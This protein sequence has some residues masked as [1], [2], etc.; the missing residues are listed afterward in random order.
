MDFNNFYISGNGNECLVQVSYLLVYF[1][2]D[3]NMTS[4]SRSRH[5]WA[6]TS[7]AAC[8]A[9]VGAEQ[10]LI[11]DAVDQWPTRLHACVRANSGHCEYTLWLLICFLCTWWT[12]FH[13]TLDAVGNI[14]RVHYKNS[15]GD[16][17]ANVNFF[18]NIAQVEASAYA[19]WTSS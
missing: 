12:L 3:V 1:T 8:V 13:T 10:S 6:A 16:E 17:I 14:L 18:Y 2:C 7:S 11:G 15:S 9:R 4:L 5:W 19:H